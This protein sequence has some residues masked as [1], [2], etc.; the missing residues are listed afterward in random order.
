MSRLYEE[1]LRGDPGSHPEGL[2]RWAI[3][4][5]RLGTAEIWLRGRE[6]PASLERLQVELGL[7]GL[8]PK[9]ETA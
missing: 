1:L 9:F 2:M 7:P 6:D 3:R 5:W 8:V 4:V